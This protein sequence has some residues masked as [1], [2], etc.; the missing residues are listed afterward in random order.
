MGRAYIPAEKARKELKV[1]VSKWNSQLG[2]C[3]WF[4]DSFQ[5]ASQRVW[6]E[7]GE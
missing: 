1:A 4:P 7:T 6:D 2:K 5:F 3:G